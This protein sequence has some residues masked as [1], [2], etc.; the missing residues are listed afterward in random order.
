[1]HEYT[2]LQRVRS[3][4]AGGSLAAYAAAALLLV[5][6]ACSSAT[7]RGTECEDCSARV[8]ATLPPRLVLT[9]ESG[10]SLCPRVI[11][12]AGGNRLT[13][14]RLL[15]NDRADYS[16]APGVYGARENEALRVHCKDGTVAGLVH[17]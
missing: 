4:S 1:M 3:V 17:L 15:P 12:D 16:I 11:T 10:G 14:L 8:T 6:V 13:L 9:P 7:G 5:Q 2:V